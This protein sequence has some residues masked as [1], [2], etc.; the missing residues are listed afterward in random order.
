MPVAQYTTEKF[1]KKSLQENKIDVVLER[2]GRL[3]RDE[4][5]TTA[6]QTLGVVHGLVANFKVALEGAEGLYDCLRGISF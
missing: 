2:L 6:A 4:A 3:T 1:T 5:R